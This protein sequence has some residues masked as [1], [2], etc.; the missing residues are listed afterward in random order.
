MG[1]IYCPHITTSVSTK[2]S[3]K[4]VEEEL[5]NTDQLNTT[6][7]T[8]QDLDFEPLPTMRTIPA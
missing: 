5:H 4:N 2:L 1:V 8:E 6:S 7:T 3:G